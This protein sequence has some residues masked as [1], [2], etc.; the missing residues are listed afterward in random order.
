MF[1]TY[2][3]NNNQNISFKSVHGTLIKTHKNSKI[4]YMDLKS[5]L[6]SKIKD[7]NI[8]QIML[9]TDSRIVMEWVDDEETMN[10]IFKMKVEVEE[11][12]S[13]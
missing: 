1:N 5:P 12:T 9:I 10:E 3:A 2:E 6:Y 4:S 7:K 13:Y 11:W 8:L